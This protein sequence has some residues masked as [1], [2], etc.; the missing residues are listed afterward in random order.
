MPILYHSQLLARDGVDILDALAPPA[1]LPDYFI[2]RTVT[3]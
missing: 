1:L 2:A 3:I